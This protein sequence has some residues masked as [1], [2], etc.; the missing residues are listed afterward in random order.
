MNMDY[1]LTEVEKGINLS[2]SIEIEFIKYMLCANIGK[3]HTD[4]H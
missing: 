3:E 2:T 4:I 1:C